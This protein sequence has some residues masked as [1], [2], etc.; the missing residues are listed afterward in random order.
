MPELEVD[1]AVYGASRDCTVEYACEILHAVDYSIDKALAALM[2]T[3]RVC[4]CVC[5]GVYVCVCVLS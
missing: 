2:S 1:D 5:A 4:V 3:V